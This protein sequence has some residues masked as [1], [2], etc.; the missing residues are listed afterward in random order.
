MSQPDGDVKRRCLAWGSSD[1]GLKI[2][3]YDEENVYLD[4]AASYKA[5][6]KMIPDG[7]GLSISAETLSRRLK[8]QGLLASTGTDL[9]RDTLT[10]RKT[11]EGRRRPV[12]HLWARAFQVHAE[13]WETDYTPRH[14]KYRAEN[15]A[16]F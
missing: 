8:D 13:D 2:G 7:T 10:I 4:P 14:D 3:W 9:G 1:R 16:K 11:I 15:N 6:K 5:A 12:L